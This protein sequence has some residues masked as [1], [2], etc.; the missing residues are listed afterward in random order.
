MITLSKF[1]NSGGA[2]AQAAYLRA[3]TLL[4]HGI[5]LHALDHNKDDYAQFRT[6]M[7]STSERLVLD[8]PVEEVFVVVAEV[9]KTFE[10]YNRRT[11]IKL[12]TQFSELQGIIATFGSAVARM[13]GASDSSLARLREIQSKLVVSEDLGNLREMKVQLST[14]LDEIA[15][16][17]E[18]HRKNS[19]DGLALLSVEAEAI[20][21]RASQLQKQMTTDPAT[22]LPLRAEAEAELAQIAETSQPAV[23]MVFALKRLKQVNLRF[24]TAVGDGMVKRLCAYLATGLGTG[25]T[26]FRWSG[27]A[28][29]AIVKRPVPFS[30]LRQDVRA[31]VVNVPQYDVD[32]GNRSAT[33]PMS[34]GWAMFPIANPLDLIL[35]RMDGFINS[36]TSDDAYAG[37]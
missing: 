5:E 1:L 9:I 27:T 24:G 22:G 37:K 32:F 23:A 13:V 12:S 17:V 31:A 16:E 20:E 10:Q 3:L 7:A 26:W 8:I 18:T 25:D 29:V 33:L 2:E 21:A 14:C 4:I 11:A 19:E 6:D 30:Q 34:V 36:Q 15:T 35:R 28:L